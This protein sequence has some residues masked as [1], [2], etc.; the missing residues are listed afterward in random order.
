MSITSVS[1]LSGSPRN[2]IDG[3]DGG[4]FRYHGLW[5]PGVRVFRN[6]R[7]AAKAS[8]IALAFI[9]P[10]TVV[11]YYWFKSQQE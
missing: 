3:S 11:S 2:A 8:L 9:L 1:A 10:M 5:S 6:L 7:F 4:F